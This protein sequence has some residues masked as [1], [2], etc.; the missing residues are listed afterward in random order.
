MLLC[1]AMRLVL[2]RPSTGAHSS[3]SVASSGGFFCHSQVHYCV[4]AGVFTGDSDPSD[5]GMFIVE[6][7][8]FK[9]LCE[10]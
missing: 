10:S 9:Y 5:Q 7:K 6:W 1:P 8:A 4:Q 3:A 2:S